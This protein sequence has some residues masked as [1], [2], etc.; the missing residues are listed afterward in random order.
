MSRMFSPSLLPRLLARHSEGHEGNHAGARNRT[1]DGALM[2]GAVAGETTR[3]E[4][5][6]VGDEVLEQRRVL[7]VDDEVLIRAELAGSA[8]RARL[9]AATFLIEICVFFFWTCHSLA[10]SPDRFVDLA[11]NC[12]LEIECA[13]LFLVAEG[14]RASLAGRDGFLVGTGHR[15]TGEGFIGN[16]RGLGSWIYVLGRLDRVVANDGVGE[17]QIAL[18]LVHQASVAEII[19]EDVHA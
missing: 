18:H 4:L 14:P 10:S 9:L 6:T 2:L 17:V 12:F 5:A 16:G 19:E 8:P 1:R 3:H 11:E 15:R 13:F 7:V